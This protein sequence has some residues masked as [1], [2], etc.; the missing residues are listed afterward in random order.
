MKKII[1]IIS[2]LLAISY[3]NFVYAEDANNL[4]EN[5]EETLGISSF[6]EESEKYTEEVFKDNDLNA[7]YKNALSGNISLKG[8][9]RSFIKVS[10]YRNCKN[11][12]N[13][14]LYFDYYNYT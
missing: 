5:Q 10:W 11:Y 12:K 8:I 14:W 7:L 4:I 13:T 6:I 3:T 1:F 2:F 9:P